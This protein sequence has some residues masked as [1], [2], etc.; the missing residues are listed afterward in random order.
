M[1]HLAY[2]PILPY[3]AVCVLYG[4]L[5]KLFAIKGP[6]FEMTCRSLQWEPMRTEFTVGTY[7]NV[8]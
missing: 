1:V 5:F 7:V 3:I 2:R 4:V 6:V 8:V